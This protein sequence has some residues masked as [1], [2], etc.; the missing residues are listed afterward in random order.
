L[1]QPPRKRF[2]TAPWRYAGV[3]IVVPAFNEEANLGRLLTC[4]DEA[5]EGAHLAC[6]LIVVDDGSTDRTSE[7]LTE[8]QSRFPLTILRHEKNKGLGS[9]I[10]DGLLLAAKESADDDVVVTMDADETHTP[11]L[12]LQMLAAITEGRDVVIASR[13]RR[14]S[15]TVGVPLIRR[16]LSGSASLLFRCVFPTPGVRD[17]TSGYRAYRCGAL[18]LAIASYGDR[19]VEPDGFQCTVDLLLK[20][21]KL[22]LVMG[23][24]PLILRYDLKEG[25][26]KM[27]LVK[28]TLQT[29]ALLSRRRLGL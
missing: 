23:E 20:L 27:R 3:T 16:F 11:E 26:T 10:R 14:G 15:R 22:N 7:V 6:R 2:V 1:A 13:Y 28:T 8:C 29:L 12:T 24:V 4:I 5:M 18:K 25:E 19:F 9:A 21:R 17:F